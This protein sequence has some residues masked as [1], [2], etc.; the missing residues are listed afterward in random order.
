LIERLADIPTPAGPTPGDLGTPTAFIPLTALTGG[1][2]R[3]SET[4]DD[5]D[6]A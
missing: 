5:K 3:P 2:S 4:T 6:T 1:L